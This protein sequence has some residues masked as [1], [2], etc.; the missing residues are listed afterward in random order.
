M[1]LFVR[2]FVD[3]IVPAFAVIGAGAVMDRGL[4]VDR[5]SMSRLAIYLLMP[6]FV[7]S[8][9]TQSVVAPAQFGVMLLLVLVLTLAMCAIAL[10]VGAALRWPARTID[11]LVLSAAFHNAGNLGLSIILFAFGQDGLELGTVFFVGKTSHRAR[12]RPF[13]PPAAM[14]AAPRRLRR[15]SDSP[16]CMPSVW[17]W[18]C[19]RCTSRCQSRWPA[20]FR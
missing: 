8:S 10:L 5:K 20:P 15:C 1:P 19:E 16:E 13:L 6:C 14:V 11:A 2:I 17:L 7:F 4:H 3:N 9:I 18:L 12:W